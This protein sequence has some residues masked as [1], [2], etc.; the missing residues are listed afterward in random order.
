MVDKLILA[1]ANGHFL[2]VEM[3]GAPNITC[4][5]GGVKKQ[6]TAMFVKVNGER[7]AVNAMYKK[8][9]GVAKLI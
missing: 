3:L 2:V 4:N 8:V 6:A 7:K 5:V 9:D 1:G